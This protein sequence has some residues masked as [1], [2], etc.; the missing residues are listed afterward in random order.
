MSPVQ[1]LFTIFGIIFVGFLARQRKI[2]NQNQV[3]G[4][5]V[6]L[7]KIAMPCYLFTA[8]LNY[9][10]HTLLN[11]SFIYSQS[12]RLGFCEVGRL[13]KVGF[14]FNQLIDTTFMQHSIDS[15]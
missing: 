14:K 1:S 6:F 4:F 11:T 12:S 7:F 10:I 3:E 13:S 15:N 9:D 2:I 8:T 5:E